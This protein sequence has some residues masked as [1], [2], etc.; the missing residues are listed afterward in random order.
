MATS[1]VGGTGNWSSN[2]SP[3]WNGAGIPNGV[4][5]T[6]SFADGT[7]GTTTQDI[8]GL[9]LGTIDFSLGN[10]QRTITMTNVVTLNQDGAGAG[11]ATI[12]N[13]NPNGGAANR[14]NMGG[15]TL[16][17]ADDLLVSNT[18]GSTNTSG[19]ITISTT[20]TGTGNLTISNVSNSLSSGLIV[21]G[22]A[23]TFSGNV[24]IQKGA[25]SFGALGSST[26][27][28]TLGSV[29]NGSATMVT[30]GSS[31]SIAN[32]ITVSSGTGGT[33]L[34]GS[35]NTGTSNSTYSG[36]ILLNG[37]LSDSSVKTSAGSLNFTN[38][39]SGNGMLTKLGTGISTLSGTNTYTGGTVINAGTLLVNG[40]IKGD[41]AVA[42]GGILGGTGTISP[43]AGKTLTIASGGIFSPGGI[44][45]T[46]TTGTS[47][48]NLG[49]VGDS[50]VF[51]S[52]S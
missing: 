3:G 4:G 45:A 39:I 49:S 43:G 37:D 27:A 7:A 30:S 41:V 51:S 38:T 26:N 9:T 34:L 6:A 32:N 42:N 44:A 15:G 46:Q 5:A 24:V 35:T 16:T 19:A 20:I 36:T 1:W 14:F 48:I 23:N 21:L 12:R 11:F 28:V 17:L 31:T 22:G 47:I 40:T 25:L 18:G 52:G 29:G 50:V 8:V 33:L 10:V 13:S 2:S